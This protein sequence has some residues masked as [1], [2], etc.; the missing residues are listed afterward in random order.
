MPD[1]TASYG[2]PF[3][4]IVFLSICMH[5]WREF[6]SAVWVFSPN[7]QIVCIINIH[8][9]ICQNTK[10]DCRLL[11]VLGYFLVTLCS[12]YFC[13]FR[14]LGSDNSEK[15]L[16]VGSF[17]ILSVICHLSSIVRIQPTLAYV[18]A[19]KITKSKVYYPKSS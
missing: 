12:Y 15:C 19:W 5:N 13:N 9:L 1:D 2:R 16:F 8:F 14:K 7:L 4:L 3:N 6:I 17:G 18:E 11:R 10:Y